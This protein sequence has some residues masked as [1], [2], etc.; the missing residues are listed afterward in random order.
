LA[1]SAGNSGRYGGIGHGAAGLQVPGPEAFSGA[2]LRWLEDMD[3]DGLLTAVGLR[4]GR[5]A[6]IGIGREVR[7]RR[8]HHR[9]VARL[10]GYANVDVLTIARLHLQIL[11]VDFLNSPADADRLVLPK[12]ECG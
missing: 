9:R 1:V 2:A 5:D 11:S 8:L 12:T 7:E 10:R 6:D 4:H 3:C